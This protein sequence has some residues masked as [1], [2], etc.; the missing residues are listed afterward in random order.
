MKTISLKLPEPLETR[1]AA[2]ARKTGQSRSEV[3]RAA[4]DAYL[5][6]SAASA[7]QSCLDLAGDLA[8][9]VDGPADLSTNPK[10]LKG[11]GE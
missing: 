5:T 9:C 11:H 8:G 2:A 1:L 7:R 6:G 4:L 10:H 3:V